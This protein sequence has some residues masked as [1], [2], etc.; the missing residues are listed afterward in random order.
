MEQ[1][2]VSDQGRI[3]DLHFRVLKQA[4]GRRAAGR[5]VVVVGVS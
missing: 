3:T 4:R 1:T 2:L 5:L